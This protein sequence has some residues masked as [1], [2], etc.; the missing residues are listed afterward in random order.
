MGVSQPFWEALYM[1]W[2]HVATRWLCSS[3]RCVGQPSC[4]NDFRGAIPQTKNEKIQSN[5]GYLKSWRCSI[6]KA[7]QRPCPSLRVVIDAHSWANILAWQIDLRHIPSLQSSFCLFPNIMDYELSK[8]EIRE[9]WVLHLY[10]YFLPSEPEGR[11]GHC[12][13]T[14]RR[15][16]TDIWAP[17]DCSFGV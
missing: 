1:Q 16:A 9:V 13:D 2:E 15:A 17:A 6:A 14:V 8:F 7:I 12:V 3:L 11:N 5:V 4:S 10:E